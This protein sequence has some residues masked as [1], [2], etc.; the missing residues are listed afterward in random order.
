MIYQR[1]F[2]GNKI[3]KMRDGFRNQLKYKLK[4][5]CQSYKYKEHKSKYVET[6]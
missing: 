1:I 5:E 4:C 6:Q 3:I 2:K